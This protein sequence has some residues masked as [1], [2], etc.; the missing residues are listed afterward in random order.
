MTKKYNPPETKQI[1]IQENFIRKKE[2]GLNLSL[3]WQGMLDNPFTDENVQQMQRIQQIHVSSE[4]LGKI[5]P[6]I[7]LILTVRK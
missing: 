7:T 5:G 3:L 1:K 2:R 6:K 4:E